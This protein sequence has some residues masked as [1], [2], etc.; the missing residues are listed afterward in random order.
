VR[1]KVTKCSG[2]ARSV[3]QPAHRELTP[4]IRGQ[5]PSAGRQSQN[6][7][8]PYWA[9]GI[10]DTLVE[11]AYS[12]L[13]DLAIT[14]GTALSSVRGGLSA[15]LMALPIETVSLTIEPEANQIV[16]GGDRHDN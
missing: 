11:L 8:A 5:R 4:G 15:R 16:R 13:L 1:Q 14:M 2:S 7:I 6:L 12:A 9:E 10:E 3:S